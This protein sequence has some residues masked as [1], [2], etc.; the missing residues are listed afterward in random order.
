MALWTGE[1]LSEG[2]TNEEMGGEETSALNRVKEKRE[3]GFE[4]PGRHTAVS[5]TRVPT[6]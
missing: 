1:G 6:L 4:E 3:T 2:R 5:K